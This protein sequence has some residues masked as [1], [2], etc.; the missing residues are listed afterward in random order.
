M[1]LPFE[2]GGVGALGTESLGAQ[3]APGL[4]SSSQRRRGRRRRE[5]EGN[6]SPHCLLR[7][8]FSRETF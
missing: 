1:C 4:V 7:L 6:L 8:C 3:L 2:C 5:W